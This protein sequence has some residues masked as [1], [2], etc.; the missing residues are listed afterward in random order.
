VACSV[1]QD[2]ETLSR[3]IVHVLYEMDELA[4]DAT[5]FHRMTWFVNQ[6]AA[7]IHVSNPTSTQ[8]HAQPSQPRAPQNPPTP[9]FDLPHLPDEFW[10]LTLRETTAI[11]PNPHR[12]PST[13]AV[14]ESMRPSRLPHRAAP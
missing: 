3:D 9:A 1:Q 14:L 4:A 7:C 13:L 6:F 11:T 12:S 5:I 2:H 10:F 8:T